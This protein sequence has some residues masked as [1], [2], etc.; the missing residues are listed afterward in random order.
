MV[1]VRVPQKGI[2]YVSKDINYIII[3]TQL[4]SFSDTSL[5][6]IIDMRL[7]ATTASSVL[8]ASTAEAMS[9]RRNLLATND[10][11]IMALEALGLEGNE[12]P[13]MII[14]CEL[15]PEDAIVQRG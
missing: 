14:E 1:K 5:L 2:N 6:L 11:T 15:S 8:L 3:L 9:L 7:H 4:I 13:E 10:C 12:D